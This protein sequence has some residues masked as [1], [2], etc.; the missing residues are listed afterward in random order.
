MKSAIEAMQHLF[1]KSCFSP[2]PHEKKVVSAS[3][4]FCNILLSTF[5]YMRIKKSVLLFLG[6]QF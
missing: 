5:Y 2:N 1:L 3:Y 4:T 6:S